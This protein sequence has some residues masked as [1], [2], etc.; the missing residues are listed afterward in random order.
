MILYDIYGVK[1][2]QGKEFRLNKTRKFSKHFKPVDPNTYPFNSLFLYLNFNFYIFIL[3]F[4]LLLST[5]K[6]KY[7]MKKYNKIKPSILLAEL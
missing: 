2:F 4:L 7:S 5:L 3:L 1:V 6:Y